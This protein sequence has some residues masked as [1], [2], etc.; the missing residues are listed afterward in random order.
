MTIALGGGHTAVISLDA[1]APVV[2][3]DGRTIAA[4]KQVQVAPGTKLSVLT[5]TSQG[6]FV[7]T[8]QLSVGVYARPLGLE[9]VVRLFQMPAPPSSGVMLDS[10]KGA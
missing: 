4:G 1:Q 8:P 3:L 9:T 7:V 5:G 6:V 10:L 2:R